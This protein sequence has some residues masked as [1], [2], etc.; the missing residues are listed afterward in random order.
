M[1]TL[2][3]DKQVTTLLG[4]TSVEQNAEIS[5]DGRWLAYQSDESGRFEVYVRTFPAVE[6]GVW[7]VSTTGGRQPLW[8]R[9]GRELFFLADDGSLMAVPVESAPGDS[10]FN[11]GAIVKVTSGTGFLAP[12]DGSP[13]IDFL[14]TYDVS[15]DG[16]RFLRIKVAAVDDDPQ[17][18]IVVQNWI[19]ELKRLVPVR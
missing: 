9:K 6:R 5:P 2:D 17:F 19:D 14:R 7:R 4:S 18:V 10:R 12:A 11:W 13:T 3:G 16:Q 15:A 1:L 8:A